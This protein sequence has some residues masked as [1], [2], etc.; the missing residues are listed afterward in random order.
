MRVLGDGCGCDGLLLL[1]RDL[2]GCGFF[3]FVFVCVGC[4]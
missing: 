1:L 4:V 2:C 3:C